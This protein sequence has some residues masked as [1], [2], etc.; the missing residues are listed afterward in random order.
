MTIAIRLP[1]ALGL[2]ALGMACAVAADDDRPARLTA[3]V[4]RVVDG[5]TLDLR[6]GKRNV[7]GVHLRGVDAPELGQP[8]GHEAAAALSQMVL[9]QQVDLEPLQQDNRHRQ[10]AIMFVGEQEVGAALISDGNAWADRENL[11]RSDTGLCEV[12]E[13]AREAKRGLW[14]LPAAKR[15]APW[16]YRRRMLH[17]HFTDFSEETAAHCAAAM[18]LRK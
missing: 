1:A 5:D 2:L 12:E 4:T 3:T 15:M 18:N 7:H 9:Q 17:R 16:E 14:S 10:T 13:A 11:G 6:L 8:W